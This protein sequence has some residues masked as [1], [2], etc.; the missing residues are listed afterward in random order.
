MSR[1]IANVPNPDKGHRVYIT[2]KANIVL[3]EYYP[4]YGS[5]MRRIFQL[6]QLYHEPIYQIEYRDVRV[7]M[8]PANNVIR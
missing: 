5:A 2:N 6:E 3:D 7:F 4:T 8:H 1:E